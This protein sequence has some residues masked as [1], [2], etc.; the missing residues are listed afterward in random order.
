MYEILGVLSKTRSTHTRARTLACVRC[1]RCG[2]TQETLLQNAQ[3]AN[4]ERRQYCPHCISD[5]FH[6][7]TDTRFWR[8]W[9]GMVARATDPNDPSFSHYGA[10]G[11]GLS[12]DWLRFENFFRDMFPAYRD[13]LT[14]ERVDNSLGYSKQNCRWATNMEQQSNK[15]NNRVVRYLGRDM[16]LAELCRVAK[17]SRGAITPRLNRGMTA[18]E[19]VADY[20]A[21]PYKRT[22]K[23]RRCTT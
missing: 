8:I 10:I 22:R 14:I 7:M 9:R 4:R 16:H 3:R 6:R 2:A 12:P 23:P 5:T 1:S 17:V 19:A 20:A 21:S 18:E 13:D 15:V 11:R